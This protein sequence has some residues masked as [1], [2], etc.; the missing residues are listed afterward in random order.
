MFEYEAPFK[1]DGGLLI[2]RQPGTKNFNYTVKLDGKIQ[3]F[4]LET[5]KELKF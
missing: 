5:D 2:Q 1:K 4:K 3:K